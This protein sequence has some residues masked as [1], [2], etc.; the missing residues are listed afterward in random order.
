[1]VEHIP[2]KERF[3]QGVEKLETPEFHLRLAHNNPQGIYMVGGQAWSGWFMNVERATQ[4]RDWLNRALPADE[5]SDGECQHDLLRPDT[6]IEVIDPWK[7]KCK[8]CINFF[9]LPGRPALKA[10][11]QLDSV[12]VRICD[13]SPREAAECDEVENQTGTRPGYCRA[14]GDRERPS[15]HCPASPGEDCPLTNEQ[16]LE[17][18]AANGGGSQP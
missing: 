1:M 13:C 8:V 2:S 16:C 9:D 14:E 12:R 11:E 15:C 17:R 10:S 6:T 18:A 7:A 4:L 5:T 3:N